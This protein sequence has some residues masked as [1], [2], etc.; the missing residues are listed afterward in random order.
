MTKS[1]DGRTL[2]LQ[3]QAQGGACGVFTVVVE[4]S[5]TQVHVGLAKM[6]V[7]TGVMCPMYVTERTFPAKLSG[8]IGTRS[9]IDL[10]TN[11][12]V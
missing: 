8:P 12:P 4:E 5:A 7:K 2:Y 6:P 10:A 1:P 11:A 9:V 3:T